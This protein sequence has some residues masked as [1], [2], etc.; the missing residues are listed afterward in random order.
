[1]EQAKS[2]WF[3][4]NGDRAEET[5]M[6]VLLNDPT[7]EKCG[8]GTILSFDRNTA[9]FPHATVKWDDDGKVERVL[10]DDLALAPIIEADGF[11][12]FEAEHRDYYQFPG[13]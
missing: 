6:V 5:Q 3:F 7:G 12:L 13:V 10:L 9:D 8:A 11:D 1:M 2:E 4:A